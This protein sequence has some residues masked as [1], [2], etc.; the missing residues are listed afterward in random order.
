MLRHPSAPF[1]A[2]VNDLDDGTLQSV[3]LSY[4]RCAISLETIEPRLEL[5]GKWLG[6]LETKTERRDSEFE[7]RMAADLVAASL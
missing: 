4:L 1:T 2:V 3:A 7:D 5:P 6:A